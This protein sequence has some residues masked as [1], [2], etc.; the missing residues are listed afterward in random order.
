MAALLEE[1]LLL[2]DCTAKLL[3]DDELLLVKVRLEL[4]E[5]LDD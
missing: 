4:D 3:D 5:E 2:E 1:L